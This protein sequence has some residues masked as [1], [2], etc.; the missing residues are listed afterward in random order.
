MTAAEVD[1]DPATVPTAPPRHR[2]GRLPE[3]GVALGA[4]LLLVSLAYAGGRAGIAGAELL[5]W[6]G[7]LVMFVPVVVRLLAPRL[8]E[9]EAAGS[10]AALAL[11]YFALNHL[12]SPREFRF[13]DAL[14]H[15]R[16]AQDIVTTGEL[17]T[18]NFSLPVSPSYPALEIVTAALVS[19]TGLSVFGAGLVVGLA[20]RALFTGALYLL[21]RGISGSWRVAALGSVLYTVAYYYKSLLAAFAYTGLALGF[22]VLAVYAVWRATGD[23]RARVWWPVA[24]TLA[25]ATVVTHHVTSYVLVVALTGCG[26][27]FLAVR[28]G[29]DA[30]RI[31]ALAAGT[32]AFVVGWT[33]LVAPITFGY[34]TPVVSGLLDGLAQSFAGERPRDGGLLRS[35]LADRV[36]SY[37]GFAVVAAAIPFGVRELWRTRRDDPWALVMIG[38]ALAFYAVP[39]VRVL[40]AAGGEHAARAL[41]YLFVPVAYVCAVGALAAVSRGAGRAPRV[42]PIGVALLA[43]LA[44]VGGITSGWPPHWQRLP[45]QALVGG[46]ESSIEPEGVAAARWA[47]RHLPAGAAIAADDTQYTLM[48]T[49]GRLRTLRGVAVLYEAPVLRPA[50]RALLVADR[51]D[52]LETDLRLTRALPAGGEYFPDDP[53]A[54]ARTEP[55]DPRALRKWDTVPGAARIF[56]SGNVVLH[57][58]RGVR[59]AR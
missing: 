54:H 45:G 47:A 51:I 9:R 15:W 29:R 52:Y 57:D 43:T 13:N 56:D 41:T 24:A 2:W 58:V 55:L 28:R 6:V 33:A 38:G 1:R 30:R 59:G 4:G 31:L 32:A 20:A 25:A 44:M 46:Y 21:L 7:Q 49:Y 12:Y 39:V 36:L 5:F 10:V 23:G 37:A 42:A 35:P 3:T 17:F 16:T 8:G 18:P 14:Q 48:G 19:T 22:A 27:A 11:V 26:A 40:S 50:D 53:A 34:L